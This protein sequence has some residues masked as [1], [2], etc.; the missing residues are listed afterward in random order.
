MI[1]IDTFNQISISNIQRN[2]S[3]TVD[4]SAVKYEIQVKIRYGSM[5]SVSGN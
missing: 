4:I 1:G 3:T 2:L 5:V